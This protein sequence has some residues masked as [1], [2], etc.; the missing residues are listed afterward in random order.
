[1]I[2]ASPE[3]KSY[4]LEVTNCRYDNPMVDSI[5]KVYSQD[6]CWLECAMREVLSNM[7]HP[8]HPWDQPMAPSPDGSTHICNGN[9]AK[10]FQLKLTKTMEIVAQTCPECMPE[11]EAVQYK[12]K[13]DNYA[14]DRYVM[15]K[16]A[17]IFTATQ[18]EQVIAQSSYLP[19]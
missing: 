11:C 8:C 5:F 4:E 10:E 19:F 9:L 3:I 1:M 16:D 18:V 17:D 6:N 2:T 13:I 15:C 7:S 14:T 12:T